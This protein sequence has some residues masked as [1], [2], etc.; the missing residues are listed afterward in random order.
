MAGEV[1]PLDQRPSAIT[2]AMNGSRAIP[3]RAPTAALATIRPS[4]ITRARSSCSPLRTMSR[5]SISAWRRMRT[6][7]GAGTAAGVRSRPLMPHLPPRVRGCELE[8]DLFEAAAGG[9]LRHR[10]GGDRAP[11]V[12]QHHLVGELLGLVHR[13]RGQDDG[14]TGGAQV[15]DQRPHLPADVRVEPGRRLVEEDQLG[16][17][18]DRAGEVDQLLLPAGEPAVRG[19]GE[20]VDAERRCQPAA[21]AGEWRRGR[22]GTRAVRGAARPTMRRWPAA[23]GRRG[24]WRQGSRPVLPAPRSVRCRARGCR[25]SSGSSSS[26]PRRSVRAPR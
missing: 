7:R 1:N 16:A 9:E 6:A 17:S 12:E 14:D 21:E 19:A 23:S 10:P 5:V 15:A 2:E 22:R 4:G 8:E 20:R 18:D 11:V 25:C 3:I 13:V 24:R 26:C